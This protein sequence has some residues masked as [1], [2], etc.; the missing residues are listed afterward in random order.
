M[1]R[2]LDRMSIKLTERQ[3][4]KRKY[5]Q[6]YG[7]PETLQKEDI[8]IME[9]ISPVLLEKVYFDRPDFPAIKLDRGFLIPKGVWED[10]K[11]AVALGK[12]Y[13]GNKHVEYGDL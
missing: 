13:L 11:T 3:L 6:E 1:P 10:Y 2:E 7:Y 5:Y 8:V 12:T 9:M 4:E